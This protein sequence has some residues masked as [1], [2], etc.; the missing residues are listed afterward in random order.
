MKVALLGTGTMGAGMARSMRRA[1]LDVTAWN[2]TRAKAEPLAADGVRVAESVHDAVVRHGVLA[3]V[4]AFL[5]K[6][7]TMNSLTQKVREVL[8]RK[9]CD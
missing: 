9:T 1:G 3:A 7:F 8:E 4:S 2:R 6:P 5:Q